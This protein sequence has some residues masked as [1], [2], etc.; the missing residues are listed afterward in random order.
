[1]AHMAAPF[2]AAR[3]P[4]E[5]GDGNRQGASGSLEKYIAQKY[6]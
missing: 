1:M 3:F 5:L 6:T 4:T 2:I